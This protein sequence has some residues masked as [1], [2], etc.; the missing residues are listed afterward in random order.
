VSAYGGGLLPGFYDDWIVLERE[1][2]Q[3][4]FERKMALLLDKLVEAQRW[5]EVLDWGERWIA[6]GHVP[7]PAHRAL[8]SAH[9][10]LGDMASVASMYQRCGEALQT[11]L[12]VEPASQ[13]RALYEGLQREAKKRGKEPTVEVKVARY[14]VPAH[15]S[16]FIGRERE[17]A[18][19]QRL[20]QQTLQGTGHVLLISGEPGV[21]K[22][23]L[24][25][26]LL[27]QAQA[28]GAAV[29][30][31][32]CFAEGTAPYAPM[33]EVIATTDLSD[34]ASSIVADLLIIAPS[35]RATYP[36][37]PPNLL[38]EP[39]AERR[40]IFDNVAAF[41]ALLGARARAALRRRCALGRQRHALFVASSRAACAHPAR[42]D[43]ANLPRGRI[44][45]GPPLPRTAA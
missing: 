2:L 3:A 12:G 5:P 4:V 1:R 43:R 33:A 42:A 19:A 9:A 13:T 35:L 7:E 32:E 10:G 16:H 18:E 24:A 14:N 17:L 11:E 8:M 29:L 15:S 26:E 36:A 25:R 27:S 37:V 45:R 22:T 30:L 6:L 38:L 41:F 21:G 28:S 40:R 39:Q 31:G 20:W 23:R 34:V 44:E